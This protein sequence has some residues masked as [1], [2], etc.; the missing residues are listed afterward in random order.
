MHLRKELFDLGPKL[1]METTPGIS[2]LPQRRGLRAVL[3]PFTLPGKQ[4]LTNCSGNICTVLVTFLCY[5]P[6]ISLAVS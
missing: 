1:T 3:E 6:F 4:K 5:V 2:Q